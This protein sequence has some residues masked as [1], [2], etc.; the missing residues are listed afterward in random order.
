M[1]PFQPGCCRGER[2]KSGTGENIATAVIDY[3]ESIGVS[4]ADTEIL[5]ADGTT[6]NTG[7]LNGS[8]RNMELRLGRPLQRAVCTLHQAELPLRK[9]FEHLDGPTTGPRSYSGPIGKLLKSDQLHLTPLNHHFTPLHLADIPLLSP[10]V[11]EKMST[12]AVLLHDLSQY[13]NTGIPGSDNLAQRKIGPLNHSRWLTHA[14]RIERLLLSTNP[15]QG[16]KK[17]AIILPKNRD[18]A[19]FNRLYIRLYI[20]F[21]ANNGKNRDSAH[22]AI[23]FFP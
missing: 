14:T 9:M 13:V 19:I 17:I 8:M 18:T 21:V 7:H 22:A 3:L 6:V 2:C 20:K 5:G 1:P 16:Q 12:D 23:S 10:E 11:K 15:D 4:T